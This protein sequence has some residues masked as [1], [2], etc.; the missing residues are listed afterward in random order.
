MTDLH[1][2][3][4]NS[5]FFHSARMDRRAADV[6][7]GIAAGI[8]ADGVVTVEEAQFLCQWIETQMGHL[9]DPV[10]NL[11]YQRISLMLMDGVLDPE[12][13]AELLETL[14]GFAGLK[15]SPSKQAYVVSNSL[16]L[17]KPEPEIIFES[18]MFLF[19]GTMAFGPRKECQQLVVD[20]G[21]I[22]AGS[23][24]KKV[25]YLVV[26]SIGN[27]QWK[28]TSYGTKILR[29]VELRETGV[30]IAIVGEEQWAQA[31]LG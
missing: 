25:N 12:E 16:P 24:N 15:V 1:N 2:E 13:S 23:V 30:P 9:D 8:A 28:H 7:A 22:I 4:A 14:R 20:R 10:I 3:F 6:L 29:A 18:R 31:L 27:E 17:T 21:G 11:L 19:T 26:G 5:R